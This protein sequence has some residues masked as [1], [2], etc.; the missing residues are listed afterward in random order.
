VFDVPSSP[1]IVWAMALVGL[2][3]H[4]TGREAP[5]QIQA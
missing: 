2:L 3:V 1:A 5:K 4:V